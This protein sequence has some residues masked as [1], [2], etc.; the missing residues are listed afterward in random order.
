MSEC[1][2]WPIGCIGWLN[3]ACISCVVHD[4]CSSVCVLIY[5]THR[6]LVKSGVS[7]DGQPRSSS[8]QEDLKNKPARTSGVEIS[9]EHVPQ[10]YHGRRYGVIRYMTYVTDIDGEVHTL[11]ARVDLFRKFEELDTYGRVVVDPTNL[12]RRPFF[13]HVRDL[14]RCVGFVPVGEPQDQ[15]T[16]LNITRDFFWKDRKQYVVNAIP[17]GK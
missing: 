11:V 2:N 16:E 7:V 4:F 17:S 12:R 13:V 14:G 5:R 9:P 8:D 10:R 15:A 3:G 6:R 1:I